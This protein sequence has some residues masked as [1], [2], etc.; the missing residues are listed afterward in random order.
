MDTCS[1]GNRYRKVKLN[2]N[3]SLNSAVKTGNSSWSIVG[4]DNPSFVELIAGDVV[5]KVYTDEK[6]GGTPMYGTILLI[7]RMGCGK[8]RKLCF[9]LLFGWTSFLKGM[10]CCLHIGPNFMFVGIGGNS[11]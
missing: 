2:W 10:Q 3:S 8:P 11:S 7:E 5:L 4:L 9:Y 6:E 1:H